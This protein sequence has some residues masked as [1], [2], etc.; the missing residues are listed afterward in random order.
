MENKFYVKLLENQGTLENSRLGFSVDKA[1]YL[2]NT[3]EKYNNGLITDKEVLIAIVL[4]SIPLKVKME[5]L[6]TLNINPEN[7]SED[8]K[9][10]VS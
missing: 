6:K 1:I 10:L 9:K 3:G 2:K 7:L 8:F 4:L 5:F